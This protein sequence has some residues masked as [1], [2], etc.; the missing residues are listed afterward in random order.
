[1][2]YSWIGRLNIVKMSF[3]SKL[4]HKFNA[5]SIK[6]PVRFFFAD[7]DEIIIKRTWKY[8]G[9]RIAKYKKK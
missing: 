6:I 7:I 2:L 9:T 8:K 4:T 5:I 3:L 1:M